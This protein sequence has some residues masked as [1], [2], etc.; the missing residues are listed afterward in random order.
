MQIYNE[1]RTGEGALI[2]LMFIFLCCCFVISRQQWTGAACWWKHP[3]LVAAV[4]VESLKTLL[5]PQPEHKHML[6]WGGG[7]LHI[8]LFIPNHPA[9]TKGYTPATLKATRRILQVYIYWTFAGY[10]VNKWISSSCAGD[11][12][13]MCTETVKYWVEMSVRGWMLHSFLEKKTVQNGNKDNSENR[14]RDTIAWHWWKDVEGLLTK[15]YR[16]W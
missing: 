5:L 11:L 16:F 4:V 2:N 13:D 8:I 10:A 15:V 1:H 9:R 6:H 12:I 14:M 3:A 7:I